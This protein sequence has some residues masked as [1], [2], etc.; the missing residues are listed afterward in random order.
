MEDFCF[1]SSGMAALRRSPQGSQ[2]GVEGS[3]DPFAQEPTLL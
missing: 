1:S 2:N 3:N